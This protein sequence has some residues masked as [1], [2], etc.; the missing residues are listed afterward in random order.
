MCAGVVVITDAQYVFVGEDRCG[1]TNLSWGDHTNAGEIS[2]DPDGRLHLFC[3]L[4][5]NDTFAPGIITS[6][7]RF[8]VLELDSQVVWGEGGVLTPRSQ[9]MRKKNGFRH[10]NF[11]AIYS[12]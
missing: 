2:P 7:R 11:H 5:A 12:E 3:N 1:I 6:R 9:C 10:G 4:D 8:F